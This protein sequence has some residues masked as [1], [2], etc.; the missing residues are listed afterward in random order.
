MKID[1]KERFLKKLDEGEALVVKYTSKESDSF[2]NSKVL[3]LAYD[4]LFYT[5]DIKG[6]EED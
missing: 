2:I 5:F 3:P 1:A 6:M 4:M